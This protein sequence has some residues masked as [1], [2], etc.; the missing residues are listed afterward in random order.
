MGLKVNG[1]IE[2]FQVGKKFIGVLEAN[3]L[4]TKVLPQY[5]RTFFDAFRKDLA[6]CAC[7][8]C[9]ISKSLAPTA[10][11][12]ITGKFSYLPCCDNFNENTF[13]SLCEI[14]KTDS[15]ILNQEEL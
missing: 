9:K 3:K 2:E 1:V 11:A 4:N 5:N 10:R 8:S 15:F 12:H 13:K 14:S 7:E 6:K